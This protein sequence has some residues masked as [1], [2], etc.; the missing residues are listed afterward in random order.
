MGL[1]EEARRRLSQ[2]CAAQVTGEERRRRQVGYTVQGD[3]V[4]ITE[5][6]APRYPELGTAWASRPLLRLRLEDPT[7]G[8]WVAYRP[9]D[10]K[11]TWVPAGRSGDD[12]VELLSDALAAH[13]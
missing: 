4:T 8:R 9:G 1:A 5:R 7:T 12:V 2:W 6:R 11:G 13:R 3:T 10:D